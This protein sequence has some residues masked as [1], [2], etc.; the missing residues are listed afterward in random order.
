MTRAEYELLKKARMAIAF[1]MAHP[2][3]MPP[4]TSGTLRE[5]DEYLTKNSQPKE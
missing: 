5:I 1:W 3:P 2:K 4:E